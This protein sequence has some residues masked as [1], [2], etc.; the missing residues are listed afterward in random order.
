MRKDVTVIG[1]I[2]PVKLQ[3]S[4]E[5]YSYKLLQVMDANFVAYSITNPMGVCKMLQLT[6]DGVS[7]LISSPKMFW[8]K[9]VAPHA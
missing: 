5:G 7:E 1:D 6:P 9:Y 3:G 8:F 4:E 2:N